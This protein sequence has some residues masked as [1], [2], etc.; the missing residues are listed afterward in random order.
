M[1]FVV[2]L[3]KHGNVEGMYRFVPEKTFSGI[4]S[5]FIFSFVRFQGVNIESR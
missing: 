1:N 2:F 4:K 3:E 5:D